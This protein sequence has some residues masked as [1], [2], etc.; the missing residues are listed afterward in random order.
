MKKIVLFIA[1]ILFTSPLVAQTGQLKIAFDFT[2]GDTAS[3]SLMIRHAKKVIELAGNAKLEIVCH[4]A[5][6]D[7]LVKGRT[8]VQKEIEELQRQNVLFVA[9]EATMKRRGIDKSQLLPA[10][11]TV[12]VAVLELSLKQQQGWSYIKED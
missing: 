2:E 1:V 6:L 8:T 9:C 3:F 4:N 7:M 10:V 5:G 12:P 11:T